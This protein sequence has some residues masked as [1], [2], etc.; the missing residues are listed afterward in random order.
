M[1]VIRSYNQPQVEARPI[2]NVAIS[3]NAPIGAFGNPM[4]AVGD[5]QAMQFAGEQLG[6]ASDTT[7]RIAF[8]MRKE[9]ARLASQR[10]A[11][12]S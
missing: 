3:G 11:P 6:K 12:G 9:A 2:P 10:K 5:A 7:E 1:A 4:Q 8:A